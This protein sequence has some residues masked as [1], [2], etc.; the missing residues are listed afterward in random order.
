MSGICGIVLSDQ[1]R[2]L[3]QLHLLP[4]AQAL[5]VASQDG[6]IT[7]CK[8]AVGMAAQKFPW[9]LAGL[10]E[11][12]CHER[13]VILTLHGNL[14]NLPELGPAVQPAS[15]LCAALI[16][17][18][19]NEGIDFINRL[20]GEFSLALWD[21][22]QETLYLAT[23]RFRVHPLLYYQD[24]DKFIFASRMQALLACPFPMAYSINP[25]A[26]VDVVATSFIPTPKTIFREVKKLPPA[27]ILTYC[28]GQS[29][30][31]SYWDIDFLQPDKTTRSG[32]AKKLKT[33]LADAV[34][35][36]LAND[37]AS[38][39]FGTFLSGG[40]DS[41]TLTGVLT[42]LTQRT[43]PS[44]T[45]GFEEQQ[46]NEMNY[47]KIAARAF[48]SKHHEHFVTPQE[49]YD[50][51]PVLLEA[52]DEPFA[53]ASIIPTYFCAKMAQDQGVDILYA[54]D[55]GDELF[56]GNERYATQRFFDY[57]QQ[58]PRWLRAS[59]IEPLIL[60]LTEKSKWN[61]FTKGK[62]YVQWANIPYPQ[63][64]S[65]YRFFDIVPLTTFLSDSLLAAIG[66]AYDPHSSIYYHYHQAPALSELDRQLY[67]DL[68]LAI[69]DNDLFKVTRMTETAGVAVRF[70]LL[71]HE[72]A[73]FAASVPSH[74]KMRGRQLR[75]FFKKACADLLPSEIR[76]KPKHGFGLPIPVWLRTDTHLNDMMHDLVLSPQS[77]QRG[78]F[79]KK[80]LDKLI[81]GHQTDETSFHGTT[82]WNLMILELW[83]RR[84]D[85]M[86]GANL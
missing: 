12:S 39:R 43:V 25:E 18:Y 22:R 28:R 8:N 44:F 41:T 47:A 46:F 29:R 3:Q 81:Q 68:K 82:L 55:G 15:Q 84:Y 53:N 36:R 2:H 31:T 56:A 78:F 65:W 75:T 7:T 27:H 73:E 54:G 59:L 70:P 77:R 16:Q 10:A 74:L 52:F 6:H 17:R 51:L 50:A 30:L 35:V 32:L 79:Q 11:L 60:A 86:S 37:S 4:M 80:A 9:R 57:Y 83:F 14:Y 58:A 72:F 19:L 45:I 34:A 13:P 24:P 62:K 71:D 21:G 61:V 20:R 33:S 26:V 69:S 40:I 64:L 66:A 42:R 38:D 5:D 63:R 1:H 67:V 76:R 49:T 23:D 48:N 85:G